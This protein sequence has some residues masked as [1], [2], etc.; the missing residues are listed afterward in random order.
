MTHK[1]LITGHEG[2]LGSV[3]TLAFVNAGFDVTGLDTG[4]FRDCLLVPNIGNVPNLDKDIRDIT[5]ED[6]QGF[7]TI[8]HLAALSNDPIGN[9]NPSWTDDINYHASVNLAQMAKKARVSRFLFSS[10]CIMY[11]MSEAAVVD[12]ESPLDPQTE[13]AAS[14]VKSEMAIRELAGDGFSP[15]YLRN[16]TVYG[17]SPRMRFDT[18]LNELM[19]NAV[20]TGKVV[21]HSDG[22]PWRPVIHV[23]DVARSFMNIVRS[24]IERIHNQAFNNGANH[25]NYQIIDL[26]RIV[27]DTVPGCQLEVLA[28]SGADQRTYKADFSKYARTFPEFKFE[29]SA[30]DGA[31]ELFQAFHDLGLSDSDFDGPRFIRLKWL[32]HL[33][34]S[35]AL[36]GALRWQDSTPVIS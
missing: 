22:K 16:G 35:K 27:V 1:V 6:L 25:L 26:A 4:Y 2:Y 23:N 9:L 20:T 14:K 28:E 34:E 15:T 17:L 3:M 19:G 5:D 29:W 10:S 31:T 24:P 18:V 33:L 8:I 13:Y 21:L 12:E 7:D 30:E 32:S 36:A 11:G